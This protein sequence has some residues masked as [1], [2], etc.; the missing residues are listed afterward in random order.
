MN[1]PAAQPRPHPAPAG[2]SANGVTAALR[3]RPVRR[4][5]AA[6]R[7]VI[8]D[9]AEEVFSER[10]YFGSSLRD[11]SARSGAALGVISHH[12]PTKEALFHDVVMRKRDR[13]TALIEN[14]LDNARSSLPPDTAVIEAFIKPFL[15]ACVDAH[16]DIRNYIRLTSHFMST[17]RV[18]EVAP[19]LGELLPISDLFARHLR[20][21]APQLSESSLR[22][23]V[24]LINAA[25]IFMVQ[26]TGFLEKISKGEF[27]MEAINELIDPA[28]GFFAGG[29]RALQA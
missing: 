23:A 17:Y 13:L 15:R 26:D 25:L 27:P 11:V 3:A 20:A 19:A 5:G 16:S 12:F 24:Y 6:R 9:A 29:L 4:N 28:A 2:A 1:G 8:M 7:Q 14:S 22:I 18:A 21:A 10:G